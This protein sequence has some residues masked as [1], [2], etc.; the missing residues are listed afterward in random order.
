MLRS[1]RSGYSNVANVYIHWPYCRRK[2][3]YC[4]FN[5]Y[6]DA[7]ETAVT[8]E[9]LVACLVK[10]WTTLRDQEG[11]TRAQTVFFGGGTPSLMEPQ[12]VETVL[13]KM[14]IV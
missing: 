13:R 11:I 12:A 4:N 1:I 3:N 7:R 10:E 6:L 2:C 9:R 8:R 5:K 14:Q